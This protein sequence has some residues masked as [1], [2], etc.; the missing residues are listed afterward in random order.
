MDSR[1]IQEYTIP[2]QSILNIQPVLFVNFQSPFRGFVEKEV[3]K[4]LIFWKCAIFLWRKKEDNNIQKPMLW[5]FFSLF[6]D[7]CCQTCV[8][9]ILRKNSLMIKWP[10][11]TAENG[12]ILCQQRKKFYRI[13]YWFCFYIGNAEYYINKQKMK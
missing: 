1:Y 10:R 8:F 6:S 4:C 9:V 3:P 13:G 11:L 5:Y 7:F 2:C 12:K